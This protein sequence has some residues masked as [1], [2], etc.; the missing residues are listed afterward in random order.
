MCRGAKKTVNRRVF[1]G[2]VKEFTCANRPGARL[3]KCIFQR[4]GNLW[5]LD[6]ATT[7]PLVPRQSCAPLRCFQSATLAPCRPSRFL[8]SRHPSFQLFLTPCLRKRITQYRC[9]MCLNF[10][11]V[12]RSVWRGF[13]LDILK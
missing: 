10:R 5:A 8:S 6:N 3:E 2:S 1:F 12:G 4:L 13:E 11:F 9:A 7:D